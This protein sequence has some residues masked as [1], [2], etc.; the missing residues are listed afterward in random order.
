MG[1]RCLQG[2]FHAVEFGEFGEL[3]ELGIFLL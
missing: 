1:E 2:V 3:G